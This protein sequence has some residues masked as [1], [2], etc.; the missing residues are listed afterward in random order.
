MK[1]NITTAE[2]IDKLT[3]NT[4]KLLMQMLI[5]D[6]NTVKGRKNIASQSTGSNKQAA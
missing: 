3:R 6:L 4:D 5:S 1:K 2:I